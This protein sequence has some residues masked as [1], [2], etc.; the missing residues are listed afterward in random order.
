M[1][2]GTA[3]AFSAVVSRDSFNGGTVAVVKRQ[4]PVV[5]DIVRRLLP[6]AGIQLAESKASVSIDYGLQINTANING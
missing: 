4:H 3:L 1:D 6:F 5:K 2:H